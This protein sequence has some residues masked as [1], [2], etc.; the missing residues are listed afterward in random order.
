MNLLEAEAERPSVLHG[1]PCTYQAHD[2]MSGVS[3]CPVRYMES[4]AGV[5]SQV[6][7]RLWGSAP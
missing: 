7:H 6:L 2:E 1:S 4:L 3:E 5:G